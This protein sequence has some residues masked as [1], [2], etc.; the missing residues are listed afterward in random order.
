MTP[1]LPSNRLALF[2][3][4]S[5]AACAQAPAVCVDDTCP[6]GHAC[7][8]GACSPVSPPSATGSLGRY[9]SAATHPDGRLLVATYDAT[10]GN[11][12]V[13]SQT[14]DGAQEARVVD[15]WNVLDHGLQDRDRGKWTDIAVGGADDDAH[16]IWYDSDGGSLRYTRLAGGG[17]DAAV[18]IEIVDGEGVDDRGTH[19]SVTVGADGV[20]HAAYRDEGNQRLR[21]ARRDVSGVWSSEIVPGCAGETECPDDAED[22]GEYASLVLVGGLPRVA[23][24][25]RSRGDLKLAQRDA[26]E[27]WSVST[28]DGRDVER[29]M[30]T[31]DV[32]RFASAAVDAKQRLGVAYYDA[33]HGALRYL[34]ASGATPTPVV[35]DDGVY[36][37]PRTGAGRHHLVGQHATLAFDPRDAAVIL[38]LDAGNLGLKR[39]RLM[40]SQVMEVAPM[41]GLRPGAYLSA[42][43]DADGRLVGAYGAWPQSDPAGTV[44]ATFEAPGDPN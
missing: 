1:S 7:Q 31:V 3:A 28:L 25:D 16:I 12:V 22:Y 14:A 20:V 35:V 6:S 9:T 24:Y 2:V 40:G 29:D 18:Q 32:G 36:T 23:F 38:Y 11:L 17:L 4:V 30:D 8:D 27:V 37:D 44:L 19:G 43:M 34:F 42:A 26:A 10:Y 33:T 13:A 5:L 39:A 21:Y 15:G 41:A